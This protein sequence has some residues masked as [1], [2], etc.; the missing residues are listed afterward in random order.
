MPWKSRWRDWGAT[1]CPR[2]VIIGNDV[3]EVY[4]EVMNVLG[5]ELT[6]DGGSEGKQNNRGVR[7]CLILLSRFFNR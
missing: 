3:V 5:H 6:A 7:S 2:Q 4:D 1:K